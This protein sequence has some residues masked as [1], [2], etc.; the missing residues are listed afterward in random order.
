MA[1]TDWIEGAAGLTEEEAKRINAFMKFP[2]MENLEGYKKLIQQSGLTLV[3]AEDSMS[4]SKII[5]R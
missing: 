5:R 2:Y 3:S 1:F 4:M